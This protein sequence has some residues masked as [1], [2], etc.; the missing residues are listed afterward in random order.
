MP[1]LV[2]VFVS[3]HHG[4]QEDIFTT[5]PVADLEAAGANM[6]VD[7]AGI[8]SDDFVQK[9]REGPAGRRWLVLVVT[10]GARVVA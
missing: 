3:R 6:W 8:T 5:R 4:P 7:T 1:H 2:R 10:P 9:I